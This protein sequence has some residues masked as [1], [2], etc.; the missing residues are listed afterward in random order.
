MLPSTL[1]AVLFLLLI[2]PCH[3]HIH[4]YPLR[5]LPLVASRAPSQSTPSCFHHYLG[6]RTP[7]RRHTQLQY[8][9]EW[10]SDGER[11]RIIHQGVRFLTSI[12]VWWPIL[13]NFGS[14][15]WFNFLLSGINT[16]TPNNNNTCDLVGTPLSTSS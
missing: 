13:Q 7:L 5:I 4:L 2:T 3:I 14:P 1:V 11:C 8:I 12:A 6:T 16:K 15:F 10:C 9:V